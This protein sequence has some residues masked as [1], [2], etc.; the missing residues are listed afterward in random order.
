MQDRIEQRVKHTAWYTI[1]HGTTVRETAKAL[2]V[3]KSTVH[4]DLTIR[5][6]KVDRS[7]CDRVETI[8][9]NH[10]LERHLKGGEATKKMWLALKS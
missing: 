3:S 7:L 5:L 9:Y 4:R 10:K 8:L 6:P 1:I 2:K